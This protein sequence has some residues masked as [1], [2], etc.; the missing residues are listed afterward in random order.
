MGLEEFIASMDFENNNFFYHETSRGN[1][2]GIV[3]DGLYVDGNNILGVDN[4]L[5]TTSLP[6]TMDMISNIDEFY[7]FLDLEKS[8]GNIRDVSEFIIICSPKEYNDRIVSLGKY[9][10]DGKYYIGKIDKS[11]ICGYIDM[12]TKEFVINPDYDC[13]YLYHR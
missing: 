9:Y 7:S 3:E 11:F 10:K 13:D 1:G 6:L 8:C 5:Y 4:I 12:E 2:E